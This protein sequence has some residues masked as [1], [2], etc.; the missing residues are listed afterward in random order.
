MSHSE[1][2]EKLS[3]DGEGFK[4][5]VDLAELSGTGSCLDTR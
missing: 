2:I 1:R 5:S 4:Q 3:T